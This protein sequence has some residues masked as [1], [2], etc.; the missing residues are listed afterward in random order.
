MQLFSPTV[1]F[2]TLWPYNLNQQGAFAGLVVGLI[3]GIIRMGLEW[4]QDPPHCGSGQENKQPDV[5]SEV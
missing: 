1:L 2:R 3:A 4:S 5:V